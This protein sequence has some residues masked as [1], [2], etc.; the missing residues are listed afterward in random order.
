MGKQL[1]KL[2]IAALLMLPVG[3]AF[4][5]NNQG[6]N[7]QGQNNNNQGNSRR[8]AEINPAV[9]PAVGALLVGFALLMRH[10]RKS[11]GSA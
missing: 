6:Q 3:Q 8:V 4:G 5:Q 7:N 11:A 10:R 1:G 2:L 9:L